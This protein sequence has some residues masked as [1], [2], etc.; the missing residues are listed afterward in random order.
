MACAFETMGLKILAQLFHTQSEEE[1]TH[2]MKILKYVEDVGGVV[3]LDAI[4]QPKGTYKNAE[5]IVNAA[6]ESE[7]HV[8]RMITDLV[9]LA[10]SENDYTTHSFLNWFV[11][12]QV[13]EVSSMTDLLVYP[14]ERPLEGVLP[15]PPDAAAHVRGTS[16]G[17]ARPQ[18][19]P[20][21]Q[22]ALGPV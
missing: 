19:R 17:L 21:P 14:A 12:E 6:L 9:A 16:V 15:A 18:S 8:T 2:A 1:R 13:E 7:M 10:S 22:L 3:M 11:D 5:T 4:A 20:A